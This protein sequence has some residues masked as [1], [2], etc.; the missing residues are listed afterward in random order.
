KIHR[1]DPS[2]RRLFDDLADT[3]REAPGVGLAAPQ[4]GV[5]LR[6]IVTY[7]DEKINI[8]I[9]PQIVERSGEEVEDTEG[10]LSIPGWWGPVKR[11]PSVTVR[12]MGRTGKSLKIKAEGLQ[13]RVL[14]HEIDHLDGIL[15]IDR[16]EDRSKLYRV[17]SP[18]EEE[19]LEH[20]SAYT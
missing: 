16:M 3:V 10:C 5:P 4:I 6:A 11:D 19:E 13:A 9:N 20:E 1:I 12:G 7:L 15:F 2:V 8:L 14:Q 17:E 18:A